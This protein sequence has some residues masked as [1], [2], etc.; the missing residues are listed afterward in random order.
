MKEIDKK[1][2]STMALI[3]TGFLI[4][5]VFAHAIFLAPQ[6]KVKK[7]LHIRTD[8]ARAQYD[9]ALKA[10]EPESRKTFAGQIE[11]IRNRFGDFTI[12]FED[13]SNL[14]FDISQMADKLQVSAL[15]IKTKTNQPIKDCTRISENQIYVSFNGSFGQFLGL[16]NAL[17]RYRPV[18][19]VTKFSVEGQNV[20]FGSE[21]N[22]DLAVFVTNHGEI[23]RAGN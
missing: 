10:M 16:L 19:F 22:M 9:D 7:R 13:S 1:Y 17:E 6:N 12:N 15:S 18:V 2:V 3:W 8:E 5:F 21:V 23:A 14:T 4:L 20:S 11:Q